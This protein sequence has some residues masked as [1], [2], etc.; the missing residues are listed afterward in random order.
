MTRHC[1]AYVAAAALTA[2][3]AAPAFA[4]DG[5]PPPPG[6]MPPGP[7]PGWVHP[8]APQYPGPDGMPRDGYRHGPEGAGPDHAG[9]PFRRPLPLGAYPGE[10]GPYPAGPMMHGPVSWGGPGPAYGGYGYGY[11]Y[12]SG[13]AACGC[14]ALPPVMWVPVPVETRYR[15]SAPIRHEREIVE[16]RVVR[17]KVVEAKTVPVRRETKY[18]KSAPST[19]YTKDKI[20]RTT[21]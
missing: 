12:S 9:V 17:E 5:P 21:K 2:A 20:V 19:K 15:Y 10:P 14:A 1:L 13:P 4:Q 18:V 6:A 7:P 11:Q 8:Q 3:A 16:E